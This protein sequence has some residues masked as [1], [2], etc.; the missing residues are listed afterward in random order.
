[1]VENIWFQVIGHSASEKQKF[2]KAAHDEAW[3][4]ILRKSPQIGPEL[5]KM[6]T[7]KK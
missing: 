2:L 3:K 5:K 4:D 6:F 1:M 7:K